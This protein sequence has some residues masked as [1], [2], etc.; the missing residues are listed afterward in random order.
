MTTGHATSKAAE[1]E[2]EAARLRAGFNDLAARIALK[3]RQDRE[4]TAHLAQLERQALA[5]QTGTAQEIS[6]K[7]AK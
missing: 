7:Q 5:V 4:L 2:A 3:V 6:A 1:L